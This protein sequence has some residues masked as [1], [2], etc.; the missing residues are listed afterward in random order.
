MSK[1][2]FEIGENE[3]HIIDISANPFLKYIRIEVD[4]KRVIDVANFTPSRKFQLD[5]GE[6]EKHQ[7][8]IRIR[9]LS[10]IKLFVDGKETQNHIQ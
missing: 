7:V 3:K 4:G 1:A 9:A 8:E 10:P 5:V 6:L 2:K